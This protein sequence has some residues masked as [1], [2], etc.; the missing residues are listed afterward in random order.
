LPDSALLDLARRELGS[1]GLVSPERVIDGQ[2]VR[3]HKAYPVYDGGY[4]DALA[5][6]R[7]HLARLENLQLVGRNGTHKYN[8]Q[9]HSMLTAMLAVR[10]LFGERHDIWSVNVDDEYHEEI[11]DVELA[12][13]AEQTTD[14]QLLKGT[15]PFVPIR[16]D[17]QR[18]DP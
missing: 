4:E 9:D 17:R 18:A 14:V 10:N 6:V 3:V 1:I 8:N 11:S 12:A 13:R 16:I 15:Q 5:A 2:V 7:Q